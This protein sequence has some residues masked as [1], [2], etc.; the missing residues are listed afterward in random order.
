M[1]YFAHETAAE[2]YAQ[3]RPYF[4]PLVIE[5]IRAF[6]GLATRVPVGI[7]VACGTGQSALALTDIADSVIAADISPAML[8]H[9]PAHPRIRYEEAP[10]EQLCGESHSADL[11][12][13]AL[14]FHWLDRTRFLAEARRILRPEGTLV[15][16]WNDFYAEMKEN[17]EFVRWVR[18][19]YAA[20]YPK[21]PRNGEP[22]TDDEARACGFVF[23]GRER[24]TNEVVFR[25]AELVGYLMTH[26]NVIAAVEVGGE[27]SGDV[28]AWLLDA[29]S[30]LFPAGTGT[31]IFGGEIWYLRSL[32]DSLDRAADLIKPPPQSESTP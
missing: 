9:A 17:P 20:R 25:P 5:R 1:N 2:R 7:D 28:Y 8:A 32:Q 26:S 4:H 12:T 19:G 27:S 24:Y 30:P 21:P 18:N 29:V 11:I 10:A 22:L 14:A 16:Y 15:I 23:A 31:F 13:V 3:S 6:L